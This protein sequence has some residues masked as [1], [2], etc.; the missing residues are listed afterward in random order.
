M[1]NLTESEAAGRAAEYNRGDPDWFCPLIDGQCKSNCLCYRK[2]WIEKL[3][4]REVY[5]RRE[6]TWVVHGPEC[7]NPMLI[8]GGIA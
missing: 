7:A 5:I 6:E 2:A 4:A 8:K 3:P 1:N